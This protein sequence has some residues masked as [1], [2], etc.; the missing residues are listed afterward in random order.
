MIKGKNILGEGSEIAALV[1]QWVHWLELV[2]R[3]LDG[4]EAI[5]LET[6]VKLP[7]GYYSHFVQVKLIVMY[8]VDLNCHHLF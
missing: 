5:Q 4:I 8:A 7:L 3:G 6:S 2:L 1:H